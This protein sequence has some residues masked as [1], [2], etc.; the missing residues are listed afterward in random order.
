MALVF[1]RS[2]DE[3]LQEIR[4][5]LR[6]IGLTNVD[7]GGSISGQ[8]SNIFSRVLSRFYDELDI[9][10]SQTFV[11]ESSAP[12]LDA[13]GALFALERDTDESDDAFR[14]RIVGRAIDADIVNITAILGRVARIDGVREATVFPFTHGTGSFSIRVLP[15]TLEP[16]SVLLD[17]VQVVLDESVAFGIRAE[18]FIPELIPIDIDVKLFFRDDISEERRVTVKQ[19][20][21]R[22]LILF[23]NNL[24]IGEGYGITKIIGITTTTNEVLK[25]EITLYRINNVVSLLKDFTPPEDGKIVA[26]GILVN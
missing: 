15:V 21:Q 6:S 9:N 20:V 4:D 26:G 22:E 5:E 8:I 11:S 2:F 16:D 3:I 12:F 1:K 7:T 10:V 19:S 18:A 13:I 25:S 17:T 23:L 14:L 24:G